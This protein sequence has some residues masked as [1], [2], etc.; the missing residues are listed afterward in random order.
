MQIRFSGDTVYNLKD[1]A[2][3]GVRYPHI[4]KIPNFGAYV[5]YS[6]PD[7]FYKALRA[8]IKRG[9]NYEPLADAIW[10]SPTEIS[11]PIVERGEIRIE[12]AAKVKDITADT[13]DSYEFEISETA[14]S[15]M[16]YYAAALLV[17]KEDYSQHQLLMQQYVEKM[18]N[19]DNETGLKRIQRKV[20]RVY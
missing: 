11:I 20:K 3:Y 10:E 7:D 6:M 19:I 17:Q 15:A 1:I 4:D 12:Y 5:G 2:L 9:T 8:D 14:Q 13:A 18:A 16:V